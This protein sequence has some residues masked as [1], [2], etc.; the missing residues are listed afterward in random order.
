MNYFFAAALG[1][2]L[3]LTL[4][5]FRLVPGAHL[6]DF[7]WRIARTILLAPRSGDAARNVLLFLPFGYAAM[8][9]FFART[10]FAAV[11]CWLIA[12]GCG[13]ALSVFVEGAQVFLPRRITNIYDVLFNGV[14]TAL[15]ATAAAWW[16]R[17]KP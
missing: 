11:T 8:S 5:P 2:I 13:V 3:F 16:P 9:V 15:G 1:T 17:R 6:S 14:G 10:R 4:F 12:I 7:G